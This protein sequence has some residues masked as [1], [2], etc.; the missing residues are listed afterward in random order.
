MAGRWCRGAAGCILL[1]L[2]T[3]VA[4][5]AEPMP[6]LLEDQPAYKWSAPPL[7]KG[8]WVAGLRVVAHGVT[9][10]TTVATEASS[11]LLGFYNG[12]VRTR[13]PPIAGQE[14]SLD[15][16]AGLLTPLALARLAVPEWP[17]RPPLLV[18]DAGLPITFDL[19]PGVFFTA[20][21]WASFAVGRVHEGDASAVELLGRAGLSGG[22]AGGV[23]QVHLTSRIGFVI[24]QDL[25]ADAHGGPARL[26]GRS[27]GALTFGIGKLRANVGV[28]LLAAIPLNERGSPVF[29]PLPAFDLWGRW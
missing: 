4:R 24:G 11:V 23:L 9:D 12:R 13:L 29:R 7:E 25:G 21:P 16:G 10:Q 19:R 14:I 28:G 5:S 1:G 8:E 2:T 22:G 20:R 26:V 6:G 27:T 15:A 3:G 17:S 18:L